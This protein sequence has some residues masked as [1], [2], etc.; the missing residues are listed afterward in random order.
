MDNNVLIA[1]V[2]CAPSGQLS[3]GQLHRGGSQGSTR[4]P[5]P[6]VP[7]VAFP[8]RGCLHPLLYGF[9]NCVPTIPWLCAVSLLPCLLMV[10]LIFQVITVHTFASGSN[11][12]MLGISA[13]TLDVSSVCFDAVT[14]N[15][16]PDTEAKSF[17]V[18]RRFSE[19]C[20]CDML[21]C[22]LRGMWRW[23]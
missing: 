21:C 22:V 23:N 7:A 16:T 10:L 20:C 14:L 17:F 11:A 2:L 9:S 12:K 6:C 5:S 18:G 13:T 15:T 1:G 4:C 19:V 8:N 3:F